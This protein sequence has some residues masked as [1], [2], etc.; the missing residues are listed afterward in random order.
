[1]EALYQLFLWSFPHIQWIFKCFCLKSAQTF[2]VLNCLGTRHFETAFVITISDNF[3]SR[4]STAN[5][6]GY[7]DALRPHLAPAGS[8]LQGSS[9]EAPRHLPWYFYTM[10][11]SINYSVLALQLQRNQR[12]SL[13]HQNLPRVDEVDIHAARVHEILE[14]HCFSSNLFT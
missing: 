4:P 14:F 1:M 11:T 10:R 12:L 3:H 9:I 6:S 8:H 7:C 5:L 2:K 13:G